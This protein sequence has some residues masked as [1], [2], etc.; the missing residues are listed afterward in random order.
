MLG[1]NRIQEGYPEPTECTV[2]LRTRRL[3]KVAVRSRAVIG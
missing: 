3:V 2:F 1:K